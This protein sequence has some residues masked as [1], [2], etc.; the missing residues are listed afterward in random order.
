MLDPRFPNLGN[1]IFG[2]FW[3]LFMDPKIQLNLD[4]ISRSLVNWW[5]LRPP[6][7]RIID[8]NHLTMMGSDDRFGSSFWSLQDLQGYELSILA[9]RL[10]HE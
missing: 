1:P 6:I 10:D 7:T 5:S 8:P 2:P 9:R 4:L 3:G